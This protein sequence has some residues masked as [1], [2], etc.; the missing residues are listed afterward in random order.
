MR[1]WWLL[2]ERACALGQLDGPRLGCL[3]PKKATEQVP[4]MDQPDSE[5]FWSQ[6]PPHPRGSSHIP[7]SRMDTPSRQPLCPSGLVVSQGSAQLSL[8][9]LIPAILPRTLE[10]GPPPPPGQT[11]ACQAEP[12]SRPSLASAGTQPL[13]TLAG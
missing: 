13:P 10:V 2:L 1:S 9:G 4:E 5:T 3:S 12:T 6:C 7:L 11:R 8:L